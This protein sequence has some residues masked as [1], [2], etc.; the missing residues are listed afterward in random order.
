MPLLTLARPDQTPR[1][2]ACGRGLCGPIR[3]LPGA[4]GTV[5]VPLRC[6]RCGEAVEIVAHAAAPW[7]RA[8]LRAVNE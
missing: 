4:Q 7:R 6:R 2:P 5:L 1:C 3:S 8:V